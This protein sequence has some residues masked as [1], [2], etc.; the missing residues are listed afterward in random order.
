MW[1][2]GIVKPDRKVE[3]LARIEEKQSGMQPIRGR[4]MSADRMM[5][6]I[7]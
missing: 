6:D 4:T 3:E 7:N 2:E 5:R 1:K